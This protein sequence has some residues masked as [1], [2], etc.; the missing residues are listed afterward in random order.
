LHWY[1]L[2]ADSRSFI[3]NI[4]NIP[5]YFRSHRSWSSPVGNTRCKIPMFTG[6]GG[7]ILTN[8]FLSGHFRPWYLSWYKWWAT[9]ALQSSKPYMKCISASPWFQYNV[10]TTCNHHTLNTQ[11]LYTSPIKI[12]EFSEIVSDWY[13]D[14]LN[15]VN[16]GTIWGSYEIQFLSGFRKP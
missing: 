5:F 16:D 12:L 9:T 15:A 4:Q 3:F 8:V 14:C 11:L 1:P 13:N 10:S 7:W 2:Y 6:G